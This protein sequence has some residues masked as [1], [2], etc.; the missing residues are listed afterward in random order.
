MSRENDAHTE[1]SAEGHATARAGKATRV[2]A[3]WVAPVFGLSAFWSYLRFPSLFGIVYGFAPGA[4]APGVREAPFIALLCLTALLSLAGVFQ[5][6]RVDRLLVERRPVATGLACLGA[7]GSLAAICFSNLPVMV[8]V[9]VSFVAIGFV[10]TLLMWATYSSAEGMSPSYVFVLSL[11]YFVSIVLFSRLGVVARAVGPET[12]AVFLQLLSA[13]CWLAAEPPTGE[14]GATT[15][16]GAQPTR[17]L[18]NPLAFMLA[19]FLLVGSPIRGI[20]DLAF[21]EP[22][23]RYLL[24]IPVYGAMAVIAGIWCAREQRGQGEK[25]SPRESLRSQRTR[26]RFI[27][28]CMVALAVCFLLGMV[29]FMLTPYKEVCGGIVVMAR[30][31]LDLVLWMLLSDIAHEGRAP[32]VALFVVYSMLTEVASWFIS[33][34]VIPAFVDPRLLIAEPGAADML[35]V[36]LLVIVGGFVIA[37]ACVM[38]ASDRMLIGVATWGDW[39]TDILVQSDIADVQTG[40]ATEARR[41]RTEEERREAAIGELTSY[42][43]LS[44]REASVIWLYA[45]GYSFGKVADQLGI[46][47]STVQTHLRN[48]YR[49]LALHTKD[50]LVEL[51]R[52]Y[53][54]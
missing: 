6:D 36:V 44:A 37:G 53:G 45:Q 15:R 31:L 24:S 18:F 51:V 43:G 47:K 10:A 5:S 49:K 20:V 41:E 22:V 19:C 28:L 16:K 25:P 7:I 4:A 2:L 33:Y 21:A 40:A 30:S 12:M 3:R 39:E 50:D 17:G 8:A 48:S 46:S 27:L 23:S 13:L 54:G 38:A 14:S 52:K 42:H 1:E 32:T 11:S 9:S 34:M 35:S 26:T 29:S